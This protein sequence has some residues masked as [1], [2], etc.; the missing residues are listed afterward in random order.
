M[1][2]ELVTDE[3]WEVLEPLLPEEAPKPNGGRPRVD[4]RAALTGIIFVLKS[5]IPWEMLPQ[6]MGCGSGMTC[7][8]RLKE[9]HEAGVWEKLHQKLLDRLG[10]AEEIDWERASLDSF[11]VAA[12][13]GKKTGANP[14]DK[15]KSGSKRHIV[16]DRNGIPLSVIHSAANVHDDSKVLEEAVDAISPIRKPHRGRPRKRPEKLHAYTRPTTSLDAAKRS[17]R[18]A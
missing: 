4:N 11:S 16:V 12:P 10:K 15:G 1:A 14:T 17:E 18:G 3:L 8:R 9:W 5:G 2:R 7:W 13:G 6:E